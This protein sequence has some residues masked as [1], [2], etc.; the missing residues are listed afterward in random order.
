V[1]DLLS[2]D[3][4]A[5]LLDFVQYGLDVVVPGIKCLVSE[6]VALLE[7]NDTGEAVDFGQNTLVDN[8]V[9]NFVL[10]TLNGNSDEL[11]KS[12]K[13]NTAVVL[14]NH[15]DVVLYK[16]SDHFTKML[17]VVA[18]AFREG[19]ECEHLLLHLVFVEGHQL[20]G[21]ELANELGDQFFLLEIP[22][23]RLLH[24]V[25]HINFLVIVRRDKQVKHEVAECQRLF[26]ACGVELSSQLGVSF[27]VNIKNDLEILGSVQKF[28]L[29]DVVLDH[30]GEVLDF[31]SLEADL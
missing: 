15:S 13:S 10:C 12:F 19:F 22:R 23:V 5:S 6:L 3:K 9:S 14:F 26:L 24:D 18:S 29:V 27:V 8:H 17:F 7:D 31:L 16:L 30:V 11:A 21:Q 4:M 2:V 28:L 1:D 25:Q 20:K